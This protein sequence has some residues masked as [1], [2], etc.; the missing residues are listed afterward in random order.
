M[1]QFGPSIEPI[2]FPIPGRKRKGLTVS[3]IR[4]DGPTQNID[5]DRRKDG[6]A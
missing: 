2:T 1:M 3:Y 5:T 4:T 6:L